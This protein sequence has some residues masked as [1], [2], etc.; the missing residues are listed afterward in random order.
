MGADYISLTYKGSLTKDQVAKKV[1]GQRKEDRSYNGHQE[2]YSGDWQ[3][4]SDIGYKAS[5]VFDTFD[6]AYDWCVDKTEKHSGTAVKY[7]EYPKVPNN[8]I[9]D[10]K[11]KITEASNSLATLRSKTSEALK[12]ATSKTIGCKNCDSK[13]SREYLR[14]PKCPV[15]ST[16]LRSTTDLNR[17]SKHEDKIKELN[18]KLAEEEKKHLKNLEKK[19]VEKWLVFGVAAC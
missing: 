15:C 16:E 7:R 18:K 6:E 13:I 2:G 19:S 3:T 9:T 5:K 17:I 4:I 10:L 14:G 12:K 8:K 1:N 11:T